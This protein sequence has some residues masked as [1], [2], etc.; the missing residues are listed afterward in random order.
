MEA[1]DASP[2][3]ELINAK[4]G[5]TEAQE[6]YNLVRDMCSLEIQDPDYFAFQTKWQHFDAAARRLNLTYDDMHHDLFLQGLRNWQ[7]HYIG[8]RLDEF[9]AT[10]TSNRPIHVLGARD[11]RSSSISALIWPL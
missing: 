10:G 9:F 8:I 4:F 5:I 1:V 3:W 2:L 6:R 7:K 11:L